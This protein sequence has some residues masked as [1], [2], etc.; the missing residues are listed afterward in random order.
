MNDFYTCEC[1][2]GKTI[3]GF[4]RWS[5]SE[6]RQMTPLELADVLEELLSFSRYYEATFYF[7]ILSLKKE[8]EALE[9]HFERSKQSASCCGLITGILTAV[10]LLMVLVPAFRFS[11]ITM[12]L[13]ILTIISIVVLVPFLFW[14]VSAQED[15]KKRLPRVH[16]QLSKLVQQEEREIYGEYAEYL[17]GGYLITPEYSLSVEALELMITA[18]R[19]KRAS[20]IAEASMLCKKK[21]GKSPIP[22][23]ITAI[24]APNSPAQA[25]APAQRKKKLDML[26]DNQV[27]DIQLI[28]Q[29]SGYL[30]STLQSFASNQKANSDSPDSISATL[31]CEEEALIAEYRYLQED[32]KKRIRRVVHSFRTKQ[33]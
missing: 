30:N 6:L 21:F 20:N 18:L 26:D 8:I 29:L 10:W 32:E 4:S 7:P 25:K 22:R 24:Y 12:L 31:T 33:L 28:L 11:G 19:S 2:D 23:L 13:A 5:L 27:P 15:Y 9:N 17:I 1:R 14:F 3:T 16:N